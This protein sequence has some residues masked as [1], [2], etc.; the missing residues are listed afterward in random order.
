M[1]VVRYVNN[2]KLFIA[3]SVVFIGTGIVL[4]IL[5]ILG[6]IF[7]KAIDASTHGVIFWSSIPLGLFGVSGAI[8]LSRKV[9]NPEQKI[10]PPSALRWR[11]IAGVLA[12]L[13]S[14]YFTFNSE[15]LY[16]LVILL[17]LLGIVHFVYLERKYVFS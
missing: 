15:I 9:I 3:E 14:F 17:P 10:M 12:I 7:V 11:L 1:C 8:S 16:L 2:R 5:G 6:G 13:I 4:I